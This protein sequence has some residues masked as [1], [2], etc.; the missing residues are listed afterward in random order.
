M[1][2]GFVAGDLV[3]IR[4]AA[5]VKNSEWAYIES[6]VLNTSI[7]LVDPLTRTHA[8]GN[9]LIFGS[10]ERIEFQLDVKSILRVRMIY[11]NEGAVAADTHIRADITQFSS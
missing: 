7:I 6:I 2:A 10:A 9:T 1:A 4:E 11:S 8:A 5:L 3:Y